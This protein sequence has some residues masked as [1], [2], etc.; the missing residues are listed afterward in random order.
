MNYPT[1]GYTPKFGPQMPSP[2]FYGSPAPAPVYSSPPPTAA[3]NGPISGGFGVQPV[4]SKEE[5]LAVIADPMVAGVLMPDLSH[6]VI[7]VK[8][9]NP[10]TGASDFGEFAYVQS[11]SAEKNATAAPELVTLDVFNSTVEK[12]RE[13]IRSIKSG[14]AK[15]EVSADE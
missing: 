12:L 14:K 6:G 2:G 13:E 8:R 11:K 15:K 5:A 4:T 7:Y 1:Y 9:F 3:G 10:Q